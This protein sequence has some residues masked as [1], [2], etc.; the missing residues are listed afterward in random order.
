MAQS[1]A[2]AFLLGCD[3]SQYGRLI[4]DLE[5]NFL[6]GCNHYPGTV[7]KAYN[8]H[9]NWKQERLGWRTQTADGE[10]ALANVDD[11]SKTPRAKKITTKQ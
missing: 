11:K 8:L 7:A 10:T 6:Q 4:E 2:V 1:T 3:R 9:T 5:N